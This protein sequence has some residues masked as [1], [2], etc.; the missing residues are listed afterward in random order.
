M[1]NNKNQSG[2]ISV[3]L[4]VAF[5][6][7]FVSASVFGFWAFS[8]RGDYKNNVDAKIEDAVTLA[9][10]KAES[11][12]DVEFLEKEKSPV[13]RYSGS[14]TYGSL[15]FEYPKTWSV[16]V[17]E[18]SSGTVLDL[19]A[20]PFVVPDTGLKQPYALRAQIISTSYDKEVES[21]TRD[22]EKGTL[23]SEAYR[24]AKVQN[25]LGIKATG[26]ISRDLQGSMILLPLRDKTIK[27]FTESVE[28]L[29]DFNTIVL[30]SITFV[31]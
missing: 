31:P 15:S 20:H 7:L 30:P 10:Q 3:V 1:I 22:V 28:F 27:V 6:L 5:G 9:V 24:P 13:R 23:S 4:A 18:S 21:I 17:E 8:E 11:A 2:F 16:Y 12:K 14:S 26:E 25:A 19:Y 29:G